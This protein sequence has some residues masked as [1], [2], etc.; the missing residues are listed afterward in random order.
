MIESRYWKEEL[1]KNAK[2]IRL[3]QKRSPRW[4]ERFICNLEKDLSISFFIIR[5]LIE[6]HKVGDRTLKHK[7]KV[8]SCK[9]KG[10]AVTLLNNHRIDELYHLNNETQEARSIKFIAD[11]FIH[12]YTIY[13]SQDVWRKC[14]GVLLCSD[15]YRNHCL[16]RVPIKEIEDVFRIVG[17]DYPHSAH[18]IFNEVKGDYDVQVGNSMSN[19]RLSS[20]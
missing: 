6:L 17:N 2:K 10:I 13:T 7:I 4:T 9:T 15:Y 12:S 14:E 8:Y 19:K 16:F 1:L 3:L 18:Y 11:Q 5:K 20:K